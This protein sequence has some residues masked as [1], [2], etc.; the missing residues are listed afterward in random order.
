MFKKYNT[1]GGGKGRELYLNN[2]EL[3]KKNKLHNKNF[4]KTQKKSIT[5]K[6]I[7]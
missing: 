6:R 2:N 4:Y 5:A 1:R 7:T 3:E